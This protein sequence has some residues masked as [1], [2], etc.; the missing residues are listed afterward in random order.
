MASNSVGRGEKNGKAKGGARGPKAKHRQ[1]ADRSRALI[2][3]LRDVT[4]QLEADPAALTS[5]MVEWIESLEK[6]M[7]AAPTG[8]AKLKRMIVFDALD[9]VERG[10]TMQRLRVALVRQLN[11][12][13]GPEDGEILEKAKRD[14]YGCVQFDRAEFAVA[15]AL[16]A[17]RER[18]GDALADPWLRDDLP[19]DPLRARV[20]SLRYFLRHHV[21]VPGR[22]RTV[23]CEIDGALTD[24]DARSLVVAWGYRGARPTG[25]KDD[26]GRDKQWDVIAAVFKRIGLGACTPGTLQKE[27]SNMR[28]VEHLPN[29]YQEPVRIK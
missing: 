17:E 12:T 26:P 14:P 5:D 9:R 11:R 27:R 28:I 24:E 19:D 18:G 20:I 22:E 4:A 8:S 13:D 6:V 15:L 29:A 10:D 1:Y 16:E 3:C 2:N 25:S 7:S 23:G 21:R